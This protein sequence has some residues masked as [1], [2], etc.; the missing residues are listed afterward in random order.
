MI[1]EYNPG[2]PAVRATPFPPPN[3]D[4]ANWFNTTYGWVHSQR[5]QIRALLY[6]VDNE[7]ADRGREN[8]QADWWN[9]SLRAHETWRDCWLAA[10]NARSSLSVNIAGLQ[11]TPLQGDIGGV[12]S[13]T[14]G[15]FGYDLTY[16]VTE[17]LE[18][19]A[20]TT[21]TIAPGTRLVFAPG[22]RLVVAGQL[23]AE[24]NSVFPVYF[25]SEDEAGWGGIEF[26]PSAAGSRCQAC[27]LQNVET[28]GTALRI[29]API[30]FRYG[31]IRYVPGGT[32]ISAT[33]PI[34]LSNLIVDFA[35]TGIRLSGDEAAASRITHLTLALCQD[36]VVNAGQTLYL[37]NSILVHCGTAISTQGTGSTEIAYSLLYA[38]GQDYATGPDAH[39]TLGEGLLSADPAFI[40]FPDNLR[41]Q[42]DS[43]AVNAADPKADY[44]QE[45]GYTG[46]RA[47]MGAYGNTIDA[48]ERPPLDQMA[49]SLQATPTA[50]SGAPGTVVT[51]TVTVRNSGTVTDSYVLGVER[52]SFLA[53][54]AEGRNY[55]GRYF[56]A[57]PPQA[58]VTLPVWVE[59][60]PD[61]AP[62]AQDTTM[63]RVSGVYVARAELWL[64]TTV[65]LPPTPTPTP[66]AVPDDAPNSMA[67]I[68]ETSPNG[69]KIERYINPSG[70]ED[71]FRFELT[72]RSNINVQLTS[73]PADYDL[74]LYDADGLLLEASERRGGGRSASSARI[75]RRGTTTCG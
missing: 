29:E 67:E 25:F 66:T 21:L 23:L 35:G 43:P 27:Y 10:P 68:T 52:E 6:F 8:Q 16:R 47:D 38:N 26:R 7:D 42:P 41:L 59:I 72:E 70:D 22:R 49:V 53:R 12:I 55:Y 71:W 37:D 32:A 28:G 51:Y 54:V 17:D 1:T 30:S 33:V 75:S 63:V 31:L 56:P 15:Y 61:A 44:S 69:A 2:V 74:Y 18:V 4:W 34:T 64:T 58:E 13:G 65:E 14:L 3:N 39:L 48:P 57:V 11:A 60:P 24:G 5:P 19:P 36:G 20:G 73:L 50:L 45:L 62:G 46:G 40:S 9:A